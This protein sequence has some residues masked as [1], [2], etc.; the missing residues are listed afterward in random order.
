MVR[1][2]SSEEVTRLDEVKSCVFFKKGQ[3]LFHEGSKPSGVYCI[4]SGK[5]K[6]SRLGI[7]GKEQIIRFAKEGDMIGYRSLL[8][9]ENLTASITTLDETHACFIPKSTLLTFLEEN[10]RFSLDLMKQACHELGEAS[11]II[12]NLAQKTVRERLAEVLL[13]LKTT[14]GETDEGH[15]DVSLT[16]EELANMVGTAT[17]SV[18]RL[19]SELKDDSIIESKGRKIK[20][21]DAQQLSRIGKVY[22]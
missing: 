15:L 5:A 21:L 9:D 19:L 1:D 22:D 10:P 8:S 16:R 6:I 11:R 12:T 7:D 13:L 17:E 18:I 3:I 2:L 20:I 14:F 4:K